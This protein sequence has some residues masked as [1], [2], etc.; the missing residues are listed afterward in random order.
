MTLASA[1]P[2]ILAGLA[3][4]IGTYASTNLDNLLL[5]ATMAT[6][7]GNRRALVQGFLLASATVLAL[8]AAF[9]VVAE[10]FPPRALG[11]LGLVPIAIG[12]RL[13][14]TMH[15]E[16]RGAALPGVGAV[17]IG[18]A[19]LA[20]STD[21]IATFGP[22]LA[23]SEP[24][25]LAAMLAGYILMAALWITIIVRFSRRL[26]GLQSSNRVVQ[27]LVPLAMIAIGIYILLNTTTD[28]V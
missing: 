20:N 5:L 28:T 11:L 9:V 19:L 26:T 25:A 12:V 13:L 22:L 1:W 23:E 27:W 14:L 18:A 8:C 7:S 4:A 21:T 6:R 10:V 3:L 16:Q 15:R 24:A 2:D 17:P